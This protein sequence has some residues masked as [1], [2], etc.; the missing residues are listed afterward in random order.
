MKKDVVLM[1]IPLFRWRSDAWKKSENLEVAKSL[2]LS[3]DNF[4]KER[5]G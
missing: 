3:T 2:K 5:R 1:K 4:L